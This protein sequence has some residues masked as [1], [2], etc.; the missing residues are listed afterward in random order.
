MAFLFR[1]SS[2]NKKW[3]V[4]NSEISFPDLNPEW[5]QKI[6]S[7]LPFEKGKDST[8]RIQLIPTGNPAS[9]E[10]T[11]SWKIGLATGVD[12]GH[13]FHLI[14]PGEQ[15]GRDTYGLTPTH[16]QVLAGIQLYGIAQAGIRGC[17][18]SGPLS[19]TVGIA[20]GG[21]VALERWKL[22][23]SQTPAQQLIPE[24]ISEIRFPQQLMTEDAIPSADEVLVSR[25]GGYLR[26]TGQLSYGYSLRQSSDIGIGNFQSDL[27]YNLKVAAGLRVGYQI[28]G[29]FEIAALCGSQPGFI[30]YIVKKSR[31]SSKG[32][33]ADFGLQTGLGLNLPDTSNEFITKVMGL[34]SENVFSLF[35]KAR[36]YSDAEFLKDKLLKTCLSSLSEKL[37]GNA[38]SE[39]SGQ[40]FFQK[41]KELSKRYR[42]VDR[43]IVQLYEDYLDRLHVLLDVAKTIAALKTIEDLRSLD[44]SS[45]WEIL[46]RMIDS[47]VH[48]VLINED[49]FQK[50]IETAKQLQ[51]FIQDEEYEEVRNVVRFFPETLPLQSVL[52]RL[53]QAVDSENL[54]EVKDEKLLAFA[55]KLTGKKVDQIGTVQFLTHLRT[56]LQQLSSFQKSYYGKLKKVVQKSFQAN[57]QWGY[58]NT[59]Q[60]TALLDVEVNLREVEGQSLASLASRGDFSSLLDHYHSKLVHIHQGI[61]THAV[62]KSTCVQINLFGRISENF[63]ELLQNS[64][65]SIE[66][67]DGGLLHIYTT[68]TSSEERKRRGG[69]LTSSTFLIATA[70]QSFQPEGVREY[71]IRTLPKMSIQYDLLQQDDNTDPSEMQQI[72]EFAQMLGLIDQPVQ[73]IQQWRQEFPNGFGKVNAKYL[74]RYHPESLIAAF[75]ASV[76][77]GIDQ[78]IRNVMRSFIATRYLR[79]SEKSWSARMG[80]AYLSAQ[81]FQEYQ[82][83]GPASFISTSFQVTLP[84]WYTKRHPQSV[85]LLN[86]QKSVLTSLYRLEESFIKA[87]KKLSQTILSLDSGK[88]GIAAKELDRQVRNLVAL[89]DDLGEYRQNTFFVVLDYLVS[90]RTKG[91]TRDSSL[92]L[93][94]VQPGSSEMITKVFS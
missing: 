22:F 52:N 3:T 19:G 63:S 6:S 33:I 34:H 29:E 90:L 68:R 81:L 36:K 71:L 53:Q 56:A 17:I 70:A 28:A 37:L 51:S 21:T 72:L 62:N 88:T 59:N 13:E 48:E 35:E 44:H 23:H 30:R 7:G 4:G 60:S 8:E 89:S 9:F 82:K 93:E 1:Q 74:I 57:F 11:D 5:L 67:H 69:E 61:F 25:F 15:I 20:C 45:V 16:S 83:K 92:V 85:Q 14:W 39:D 24:T 26:L 86:A 40:A 80:F 55:E 32:V 12:A 46:P 94:I 49:A 84:E 73:L 58:C 65:E 18:P 38:P 66:E 2:L 91:K 31:S 76:I 54:T 79:M 42:K 77:N 78:E 43:K 41:M 47:D 64:E 27:E 10:S 75:H 50:L 87:Y